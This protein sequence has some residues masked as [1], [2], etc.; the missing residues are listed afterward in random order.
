MN[1]FRET[2]Q[3]F[4][5]VLQHFTNSNTFQEG[6]ALAY[7]TV[8]SVLPIIVIVSSVLGMIWGEEAVA[9][10]IYKEFRDVL[11]DEA[12]T[13][14]QAMIKSQ[15]VNHNNLLT[16]IVGFVVLALSASGMFL[17][18]YSAFNNIWKITSKPQ[19]SI[20]DYISKSIVSFC[21]LIASFFLLFTSTTLNTFLV[22]Y[23]STLLID[24]SIIILLE[25]FV[26]YFLDVLVFWL[27]YKFLGDAIVNGKVALI[28]GAF[29]AALFILGNYV[30]GLYIGQSEISST[31]GSASAVALIM[32]WVYYTSQ[33]IFLGASFLYVLG[34]RLGHKVLPSKDA[35]SFVQEEVI[36]S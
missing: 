17:Q 23:S 34:E 21:V 28:S 2:L 18:L 12:A 14:I 19:N 16:M 20:L 11:G 15:H 13:Q 7:Y 5:D 29:T 35:V 36:V 33:V 27:M 31:F 26:S 10:E 9:G 32:V 24:P 22:K 1:F 30:I 8:F 4:K 6:A 25:Y 3:F